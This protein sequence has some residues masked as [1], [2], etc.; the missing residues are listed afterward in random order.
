M[1]LVKEAQCL[2]CIEIGVFAGSSLFPI[3]TT[4][5]YKGSGKVYA[6]DAWDPLEA[7]SGCHFSDS[8]YEWWSKIDFAYFYEKTLQIISQ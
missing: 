1:D 4:L 2:N 7:L 5:K 8:N 6:I 3:A